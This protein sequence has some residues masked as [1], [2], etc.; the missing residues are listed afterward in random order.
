MEDYLGV[1]DLNKS[2]LSVLPG[3]LWEASSLGETG[4]YLPPVPARSFPEFPSRIQSMRLWP[5]CKAHLF[6]GFPGK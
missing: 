3:W 6:R 2:R 5:G 1:L 4:L